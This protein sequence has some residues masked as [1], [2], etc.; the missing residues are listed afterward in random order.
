MFCTIKKQPCKRKPFRSRIYKNP[1][2]KPL[3]EGSERVEL[4]GEEIERIPMY[5]FLVALNENYRDNGKI[6]RRQ[7]HLGTLTF[8]EIVEDFKDTYG[9]SNRFGKDC[10]GIYECGL[11]ERMDKHFK[12]I[13]ESV[14][15]DYGDI[16][17]RKL[18]SVK[19]AVISE[20]KTLPE[21]KWMKVDVRMRAEQRDREDREREEKVRQEK[22]RERKAHQRF[23]ETFG[24]FGG[25]GFTSAGIST[26]TQDEKT[27]A[28]E[29]IKAGYRKLSTKYHPDTGG[30][31]GKMQELNNLKEKLFNL[32]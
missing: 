3:Y 6:R 26:L 13:P 4:S 22:E 20:Y 25:S 23:Q 32:L 30:D 15:R 1:V 16:L 24:G 28:L 18:E 8:W 2:W 17:S 14:L 12:D 9:N 21:Y 19:A 31:V 27:L 10:I 11:W 5:K 7:W 29:I